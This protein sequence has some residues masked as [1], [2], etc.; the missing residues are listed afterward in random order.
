MSWESTALYYKIINQTI[1]HELGGLHS[2][3][4]L[5]YSVNF[6][7]IEKCQA[8]GDWDKSAKIL[9]DGALKLQTAGADYIAICTNTM[10]K[11]ANKIQQNISIPIIHIADE[12]AKALIQNK[13]STVGLL[14]TKYTMEQDFY[15]QRL[16]DRNIAIVIPNPNDRK[17]VNDTIYNELCLGTVNPLSKKKFLDILSK[18]KENGAQGIILGCT[19]IGMLLKQ[20][21][22]NIP[23]F[24]TTEIHA[25]NIA[26][27]SIEK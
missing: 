26:K 12:T 9:T 11:V 5:L 10:H 4:L 2:T 15:K 6:A 17:I 16:I 1:K 13:I 21:D 7:E 22:T 20:E 3:K 25:K 24:D 14:G 23:L 27:M 18:L 8:S 19:E